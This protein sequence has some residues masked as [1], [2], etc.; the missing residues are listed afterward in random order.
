MSADSFD[1][2]IRFCIVSGG[3]EHSGINI[4]NM[5]C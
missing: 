5:L 1:F 3:N 2:H 4:E